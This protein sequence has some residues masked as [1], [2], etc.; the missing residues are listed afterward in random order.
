MNINRF[1][2]QYPRNC[3]RG[4]PMGDSGYVNPDQPHNGLLCQRITLVNGDY[5]PDGTYW[6]YVPLPDRASPLE[7]T[8]YPIEEVAR[9]TAPRFQIRM[10]HADGTQSHMIHNDRTHW[11]RR[12]AKRHQSD[13]VRGMVAG[14]FPHVT[15]VA[16]V[17]V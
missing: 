16:L 15:A 14:Y 17:A 7:D 10:T 12:V 13:F 9:L 11:C 6:G 3:S 4:A 1:L 8:S 2:R 5:G